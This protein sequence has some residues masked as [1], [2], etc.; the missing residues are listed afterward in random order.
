MERLKFFLALSILL[1]LASSCA[2]GQGGEPEAYGAL[3]AA[4]QLEQAKAQALPTE[5]ESPS[6]RLSATQLLPPEESPPSR[7]SEEALAEAK[8]SEA[9]C[10]AKLS[11]H[12]LDVGQG[13]SILAMCD[14]KTMLV[15]SGE[16][17]CASK[18]M[19]YIDGQGIETIDYLVATH[20]RSDYLA[21]SAQ[22]IGRLEVKEIL[23]PKLPQNSYVLDEMLNIAIENGLKSSQAHKGQSFS[24]GSANVEVLGPSRIVEGNSNNNSIALRI[25]LGSKS[26]L[27]AGDAEI[28]EESDLLASGMSIRSNVLKV[29]FHGNGASS[30][31]DF[32]GAVKPEI[33]VISVGAGNN[34]GHPSPE[35]LSR[36]G[37]VG[38]TVYRTDLDGDIIIETDGESLNIRGLYGAFPVLALSSEPLS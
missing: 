29:G 16:R 20:P 14:G 34:C 7:A 19:G 24:L 5:G 36:L 26:F 27:L 3:H 21:R 28:E 22:M 1:A 4:V 18:V 10:E 9:P 33:A 11:V 30:G 2:A 15:D 23:T 17:E 12:F 32:I 25:T 38:A 13:D 8:S 31:E 35:T 37:S 6:K